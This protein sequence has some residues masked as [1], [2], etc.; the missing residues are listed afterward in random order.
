MAQRI[1]R[2]LFLLFVIAGGI[3]LSAQT[4]DAGVWIVGS[5]LEETSVVE[6]NDDITIDFDED[7]GWGISFNHFWTE[8][9][10]TEIAAQKFGGDMT[11]G[12]SSIEGEL[13]FTAGELDATSLTALAQLHFRRATRFAPYVGTSYQPGVVLSAKPV[14]VYAIFGG[15]WPHSSFMVPGGVMCAPNLADV[16]RSVAILAHW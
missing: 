9:F 13:N 11:V 14:E 2:I 5:R 1:Y 16:T 4:S 6:D 7:I 3:R 8:R 10:S 15:Q 12:I